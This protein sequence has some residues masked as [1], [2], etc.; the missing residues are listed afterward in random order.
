MNFWR[1]HESAG[2]T[3]S[4]DDSFAFQRSQGVTCGHQAYPMDLGQLSFRVHHIAGLEQPVSMRFQITLWTL[5]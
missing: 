3:P 2:A 5:L 1:R 4:F